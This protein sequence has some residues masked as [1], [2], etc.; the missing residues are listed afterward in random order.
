MLDIPPMPELLHISLLAALFL[1]LLSGMVADELLELL[2]P[3]LI[4]FELLLLLLEYEQLLLL[5]NPLLHEFALDGLDLIVPAPL[6]LPAFLLEL[7]DLVVKLPDDLIG[8]HVGGD[9]LRLLCLLLALFYL[10]L[11][12]FYFSLLCY[13]NLVVLS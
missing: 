8:D 7:G 9:R 3:D 12:L 1:N 2:D 5:L 6:G 13:I 4:E 11:H 10:L